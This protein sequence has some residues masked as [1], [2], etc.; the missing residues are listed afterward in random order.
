MSTM[1]PP[2]KSMQSPYGAHAYDQGHNGRSK[3]ERSKVQRGS[4]Y[5]LGRPLSAILVGKNPGQFI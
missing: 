1:K 4:Q 2:I 3:V 5:V